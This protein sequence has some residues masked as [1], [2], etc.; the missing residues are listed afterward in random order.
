MWG[1]LLRILTSIILTGI[2]AYLSYRK[3]EVPPPGTLDDIGNPQAKEG[4]EIIKAFGTITIAD[5]Q[6][7]WFGDFRAAPIIEKGGRKYGLVGPKQKI[8]IGY[9]YFLGIHFVLCLGPID[10][11]RRLRIDKRVAWDGLEDAGS[12]TINKPTLFGS[13]KREGGVSGVV[14]VL[15]GDLDQP[16][17]DYLSARQSAPV[18]AYRGVASLVFRQ[19]YIGNNPNLR[20]WDADVQRIFKTDP[21]YNDG[22]QWYS[23]KAAILRSPA[24]APVEVFPYGSTWQYVQIDFFG[25]GPDEVFDGDFENPYSELLPAPFYDEVGHDPMDPEYPTGTY[26]GAVTSQ[27]IWLRR[28]FTATSSG[29]Y[30]FTGAVENAIAVYLDGEKIWEP[31][32]S[33]SLIGADDIFEFLMGSGPHTFHIWWRDDFIRTA[34]FDAKFEYLGP[35]TLD[36]NPVHILREVLLSPDGG[37]TGNGAEAGSTWEAAADTIYDEGFGISIGW[38]GGTDRVDFKKEIERHIDA[39]SYID[40]RTGLW[41]IKLI[42]DDYDEETLPVFDTSNVASWSNINFPQPGSLLNQLVVVWNAPEKS[43]QTSLTISNPA[44]IRMNGSQVFQE[45]VEYLGIQREDLAGRVAMRDLSAR[46]APLVTGEFV[47][48]NFPTDL[49][50]GSVI[51]VHNPR[52]GLFNKIVRV[53]EIDDGNIRDSAVRVKFLEDRFAI[54][55][56]SKL[57]IEVI[58]PTVNEPQPVDPRMVEEAP[59]ALVVERVGLPNAELVFTDDV[60]AGFLFVAGGQPTPTSLDAAIFRDLGAGYEELSAVTFVEGAQTLGVMNARADQP[61]VVVESIDDLTALVTGTLAWIEGEH[62]VVDLVEVGDTSAPGDYWEPTETEEAGYTVYTVTFKRGAMDTVPASH[63][64]NAPVVFYGVS[65]TFEDDIQTDGDVANIKLQTNDVFGVL[66]FSLAPI[67]TVTFDS[68][69]NRPYAPGQF[70]L[71]GSYEQNSLVGE[72]EFTWVHRDRLADSTATPV[73]HDDAGVTSEVGV[74]YRVRADAYNLAGVF[75]ETFID[76]NVG[77]LLT[78]SWDGLTPEVPVDAS[79]VVW[80]VTSVRDTYES[81][82][83][84]SIR[85]IVFRPPGDLAFEVI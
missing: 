18:P 23:G 53:T 36:M 4:T 44:R 50:L 32:P 37:G 7:V 55:D 41:E 13:A 33:N 81:W 51:I 3:P 85:T 26:V 84:P 12:I 25:S 76:E 40:R 79:T 57:E 6:V 59:R 77:A 27:G 73:S 68:R 29:V 14:N 45:K 38:R 34:Y 54:G 49:N 43:E 24:P 74:T 16:V 82:Q 20:P 58:P 47:C 69:A 67:D 17:N 75:L 5:P 80:K 56:E 28:S 8:T 61:K 22:L 71:N 78:Y 60:D 19:F 42:R 70:K 65:G 9:Q 64:V 39:R 63:A 48:K 30:R 72:Y 52:L 31:N 83:S 35:N 46:S 11:V 15:N 66:D 21:A 1:F 2:S 10:F 62:L